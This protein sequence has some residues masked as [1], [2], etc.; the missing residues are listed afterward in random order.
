MNIAIEI[1]KCC[2]KLCGFGQ[3]RVKTQ[4]QKKNQA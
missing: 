3:K 4:Q 1:A 2:D